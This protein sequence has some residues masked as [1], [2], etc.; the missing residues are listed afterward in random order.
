LSRRL[1]V[2]AEHVVHFVCAAMTRSEGVVIGTDDWSIGQGK[3]PITLTTG[4]FLDSASHLYPH[5]TNL[6]GTDST[7]TPVRELH[8][9]IEMFSAREL[10]FDSDRL[11]ALRGILSRSPVCS[12]YG[13]PFGVDPWRPD[14]T[15]RLE[16]GFLRSLS[17][18]TI[19]PSNKSGPAFPSWSWASRLGPVSFG[20]LET[21]RVKVR[22]RKPRS[23]SLGWTR[24]C[25]A[26]SSGRGSCPSFPINSS[27]RH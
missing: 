24:P 3:R 18:V 14:D 2:F 7:S 22:L 25:K 5:T 15:A 11:N 17:W 9:H 26:V 13:I 27:S 4:G 19:L 23:R 16:L 10:T 20:H 1:I 21:F 8:G 6:P 12:Y